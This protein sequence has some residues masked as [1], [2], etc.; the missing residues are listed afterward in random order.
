MTKNV[1]AITLNIPSSRTAIIDG[2]TVAF[3]QTK[4]MPKMSF[5]KIENKWVPEVPT[6]DAGSLGKGSQPTKLHGLTGPIDD[7]FMDSFIFV[8]PTGKPLNSS[9]GGWVNSELDRAI[10]QWRRVFRGERRAPSTS[11]RAG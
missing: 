1:A 11:R 2:Q 6:P 10:V 3:P 7:A 8:R 4:T 5:Q 9:V